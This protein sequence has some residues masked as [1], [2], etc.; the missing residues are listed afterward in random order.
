MAVLVLEVNV[1]FEVAVAR[2][3]DASKQNMGSDK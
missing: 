3:H 2:S 1:L